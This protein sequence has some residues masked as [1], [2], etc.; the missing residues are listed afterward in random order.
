MGTSFIAIYRGETISGARLIA[1]TTDPELVS[2]VTGRILEMHPQGA[3][4][5]IVECVEQGRRAALR[6]IKTESREG[7]GA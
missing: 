5:P 1:L 4:D 3:D 7:V 2:E 6:L